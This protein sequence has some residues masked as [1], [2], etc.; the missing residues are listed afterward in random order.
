MWFNCFDSI[1]RFLLVLHYKDSMGLIWRWKLSRKIHSSNTITRVRY[2]IRLRLWDFIVFILLTGICR[3]SITWE[4]LNRWQQ[5]PEVDQTKDLIVLI[6]LTGFCWYSVT[7]DTL[8][9]QQQC[10]EGGWPI[11]RVNKLP[12]LKE[13][14][15]PED[16]L[17][18]RMGFYCTTSYYYQSHYYRVGCL[19]HGRNFVY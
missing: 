16:W 8:N 12:W 6:L 4:T 11:P 3:S 1:S 5:F 10:P 14:E 19:L 17:S 9:R 18:L 15:F 7:W 2:W 13:E